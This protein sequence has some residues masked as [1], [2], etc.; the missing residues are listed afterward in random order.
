MKRS[1]A[2]ATYNGAEYIEEQLMSI[3]AQSKAVDEI[4]ICDDRSTDHTVEVVEKFIE[5]HHIKDICQ[6]IVNEENL[7]YASN[8]MKAVS[9]TQGEL[10]FFCD[11]DD[12]WM[13][14]RIEK[15]EKVMTENPSIMLLGSEF[16]PFSSTEDAPSVPA[17]ELNKFKGDGSVEKLEFTPENIFIGCQGCTMCIRR[18]LLDCSLKHWYPG[19]AHDE[20]VWKMALCMDGLYFFHEATLKRRLHSNNV[21]L[22]K[23]R[24]M[25]KRIQYVEDLLKSHKATLDFAKEC[26]LDK[27]KIALLEKNI[28]ATELRLQL[29]QKRKIGN[30]IP[31]FFR[32]AK[33][34]HKS[35]AI[36]VE[37]YMVLKN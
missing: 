13:E 1:V 15:M 36:L 19:F 30:T 12:I 9:L 35:R 6:I 17:W 23:V 8:F 14:D 16:E 34:Y 31:L 4:I 2:M 10:I 33:C 37:L 27:K 29:L 3:L 24:D 7:G 32:Y 21:T 26:S 28:R 18:E 5:K 22:H 20:Y 25:Q 11:Q